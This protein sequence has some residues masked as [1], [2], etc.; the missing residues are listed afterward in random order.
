MV[1]FIV[2]DGHF[3]LTILVVIAD[4]AATTAPALV[5]YVTDRRQA[6]S[7]YIIILLDL[8]SAGE[9]VHANSQINLVIEY[10]LV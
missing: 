1:K 8:A 4:I 7:G 3:L 2:A 9:K 6:L 10:R 5:V